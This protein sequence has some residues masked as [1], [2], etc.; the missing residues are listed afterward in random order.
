MSCVH[1]IIFSQNCSTSLHIAS[2]EDH[3]DVAEI[4]IGGGGYIDKKNKVKC[5][6]VLLNPPALPLA[7]PKCK[8]RKP[9][10]RLYHQEWPSFKNIHLG[11]NLWHGFLV[12]LVREHS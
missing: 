7:T 5:V 11:I 9:L 3:A 1:C 12:C 10:V 6:V 8:L 2:Q 4:L